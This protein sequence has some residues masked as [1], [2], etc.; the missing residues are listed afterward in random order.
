MIVT[1]NAGTITG[2]GMPVTI[3]AAS[4]IPPKSAV[5]LITFATARS[6]HAPQSTHRE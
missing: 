6:T 4:A 2:T 3:L 5:M 1:P